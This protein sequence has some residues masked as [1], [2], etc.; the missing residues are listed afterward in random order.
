MRTFSVLNGLSV[1]SLTTG[2]EI[3]KIIDLLFF[4]TKV[5]GVMVDKKGWLNRHLFVPIEEIYAIG[6]DALTIKD[7]ES[8]LIYDKKKFP[9]Y[10]L[11]NGV[12]H[13]GG[14]PLMTAEGET[15]GLVEDVYF[16]EKLGNIVGY[17]VTDGLIADIKEGKQV[18]KTNSPLTIGEEV[19]IIDLNC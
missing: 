4:E 10:T 11:H 14:K 8:L 15:V 3:G 1:I 16:N 19:L 2:E 5:K 12:N 6:K 9:F 18:L 17:E 13:I 7:V